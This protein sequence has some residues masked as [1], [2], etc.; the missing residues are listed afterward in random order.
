MGLQRAQEQEARANELLEQQRKQLAE[1]AAQTQNAPA[2]PAASATPPAPTGTPPTP[3]KQDEETYEARY[4]VLHGKYQA[5]VPRLHEQNRQ[6]SDRLEDVARQLSEAT[7]RLAE[8]EAGK[9]RG[10]LVK[11]E[12]VEQFGE[13]LIDVMR[14]AAREELDAVLKAKDA[15]I[16]ELREAVSGIKHETARSRTV[17]FEDALTN[18][19]PNWSVVNDDPKFHAWLLEIDPA[20]NLDRQHALDIHANA[21][22]AAKVAAVFKA[23]LKQTDTRAATAE[24]GV[25]QLLTPNSGS[26]ATPPGMVMAYTRQEIKQAFADIRAG[27]LPPKEA[28]ALEAEINAAL[29]EG[30]VI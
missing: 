24:S 20:T 16:S 15:E 30:R 19:V 1:V 2:T 17:S 23:F 7:K 4:K 29:R 13:P 27:R 28:A 22:D 12:E 26:A 18:L 25:E 6:L 10:T 14:R 5:E 11:E 8:V 9:V 21:K 3:P